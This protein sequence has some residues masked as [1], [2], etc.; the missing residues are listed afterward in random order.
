MLRGFIWSFGF[1]SDGYGY[2]NIPIKMSSRSE[3]GQGIKTSLFD[4]DSLTMK[5]EQEFHMVLI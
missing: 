5:Q 2:L 3:G 1:A 4:L